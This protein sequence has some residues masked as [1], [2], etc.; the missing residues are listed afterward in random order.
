MDITTMRGNPVGRVGLAGNPNMDQSC[1]RRAREAGIDYLF[2]YNDTYTAMTEGLKAVLSEDREEVC[3]AAGSK[4]RDAAT[5]RRTLD[6][7]RIR[8]GVETV[9]VFFA[10][11]VSPSDGMDA[12]MDTLDE[13]HRWKEKG[14]IRYVGASVHSRELALELIECGRVEILMHRYNMAHRGAE[15]KVF[16]AAIAAQIP[17]VAFTCTR[18]GSLLQGHGSWDGTVPRAGDCYRYALDHSAVRIALTA[19]ATVTQLQDNLMILTAPA[20]AAEEKGAWEE[21][22]AL[23]Y[24]DGRD[25]FE[26]EWP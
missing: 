21:Y 16:P 20:L 19:P 18:W 26:T 22:G 8:L 23:I 10:E 13:L 2:F 25:S 24:G 6:E 7:M 17:V 4:A 15:D 12:V 14:T 11:Y 5:L 1:V 9:D 3:V